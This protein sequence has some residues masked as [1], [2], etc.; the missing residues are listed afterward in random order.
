MKSK[1]LIIIGGKG[2]GGAVV[3][4]VE[5][6]RDDYQDYEYEIMGFLN[7]H[8][9]GSI[10]GYPVLGKIADYKKHLHDKNIYFF[11]A[12]HLIGRNRISDNLFS[13]L[14]IPLD[15]YATI[16]HKTAIIR[17]QAI[18]DP[19]VC[20]LAN[21]Y[22]AGVH[23]KVGTMV[24]IGVIISH[25]ADIGPLVYLST[26]CLVGSSVKIGRSSSVSLSASIIEENNIGK[27]AVVAAGAIVNCD[28]PDGSI[29]AGVPA[30]FI[31]MISD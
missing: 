25:D 5:L 16:V 29:Y 1:Q 6:N 28:I 14:E 11:Y 26:G 12:I 13:L 2:K 27:Y 31:R 3:G 10:C 18:L 4:C 30:K 7:D 24:M 23:L 17:K 9:E 19:G 21:A 15:R 20:V 8:A 22:V